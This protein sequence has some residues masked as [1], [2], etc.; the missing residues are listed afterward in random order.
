[1][2]EKHEVDKAVVFGFPWH[3]LKLCREGND[4]VLETIQQYA[5]QFIGFATLPWN[6]SD[7]ALKECE[8][9]LAGGCK[10]VGELALLPMIVPLMT[11]RV[12]VSSVISLIC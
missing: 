7:A 11:G 10:G 9:C 4:Y 1:M 6:S 3:D 12:L 8:R 5:D 2:M